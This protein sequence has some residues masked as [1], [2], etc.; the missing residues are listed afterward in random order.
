VNVD[1]SAEQRMGIHMMGG[2]VSSVQGS[3]EYFYPNKMGRIVFLAMEDVMGRNG[4]N[5][6]LNLARLQHRIGEYPPNDFAKAFAFDES[7]QLLQALDEMYGPRGGRGLARR[8]G[9][10]CFKFGIKDF[11]PML[12]IAD[13]TF[14]ILPLSMKLKVGF[15]VLAQTLNKFTDQVVRLGEDEQYFHW[16]MERCGVCWG[17]KSEQPCCHLFVGILEEGLYWLSGGKSFYVEEVSCI[18]AGDLT[19]TILIGRRPLD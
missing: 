11:G 15:E 19:C 8:A 3:P 2:P 5:A 18:A 7:A 16:I 12:G 9:H 10:S 6:I 4:V 17:R 1:A 13:L 14:R